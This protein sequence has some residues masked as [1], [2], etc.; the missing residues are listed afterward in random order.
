MTSL[1][2][3]TDEIESQPPVAERVLIVEDDPATRSG[4]AELVQA[5]GFLTDEAADGE[6][7]MRKVTTFRPAIIVSDLVMPRMG[8]ADLLRAL[9]DQLSDITLIL[10]TAQGTIDSAVEAIKE[11]AYDY[12]SKPVDPQRLQILLQKAVERQDTLREVRALRRQLRE[13]GSFGR[14]I[15]NSPGIRAVYR[16]IEQSAPTNASVLISGESGTGKELIAQT[17]HELSPRATFP[18][19]AINCAAIPETLLESEIFGHEKGAFTGATD[20]RTGVFELAHRG[21]L[22]LDEIAEMMPA[23]QVKLL[24]VL[25]ERIFRRLGGRQE[26]SVDVRVIA[27]TNQNPQ[28]AVN[29]GKLRED[30]FYRLNV[31]AI[32]LPPLRAR[33]EDIPLLVQTFLTEFNRTNAKSIRGVD[34]EAMYILERYPWP[35]NIRELRNVIERATILAE[36]EFIEPRHLPPTLISR[37]EASLPTLTIGPGTTVDEAERRLILLTLDHTRN[38]KTRAAEILGIS[39]KTLHNK[40]NRMKEDGIR[41][42]A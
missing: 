7:A 29:S 40:L 20:R 2:T 32:D 38:N 1:S 18:F 10:L 41:S 31:F 17:I 23:T 39:L 11:G 8:G 21:T 27:A 19:V 24:R 25:Q 5:W 30:L 26:I 15:G 28:D 4:L 9:K 3:M 36:S 13:Q 42:E 12:L 14:I 37:G 6:E 34:Q 22:F 33:R 16:V 35:G